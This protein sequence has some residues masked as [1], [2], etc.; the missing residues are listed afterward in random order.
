MCFLL[1]RR[2]SQR[3]N[4]RQLQSGR[5]KLVWEGEIY[6]GTVRGLLGQ[7]ESVVQD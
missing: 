7:S 3:G 4:R 5:M 2:S 1:W 6:A